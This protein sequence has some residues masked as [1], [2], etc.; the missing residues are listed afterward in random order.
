MKKKTSPLYFAI[1]GPPSLPPMEGGLAKQCW[2]GEEEA[3]F[4]ADVL[5]VVDIKNHHYK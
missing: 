4:I 3:S 5:Q 2:L 1:F